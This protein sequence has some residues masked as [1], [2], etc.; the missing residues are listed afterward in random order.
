MS[1]RKYRKHCVVRLCHRFKITTLKWAKVTG[2][3]LNGIANEAE[4]LTAKLTTIG[5]CLVRLPTR[6]GGVYVN[7]LPNSQ[8]KRLIM[9]PTLTH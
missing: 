3:L 4:Q 9:C 6:A 2:W 5:K 1:S 8:Y 7:I